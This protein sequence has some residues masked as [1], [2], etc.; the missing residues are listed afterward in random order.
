MK[1]IVMLLCC[2][3]TALIPVRVQALEVSAECACLFEPVSGTVLYEKNGSTKHAMASTTKIMTALVAME[4]SSPEE[5]VTVSAR[6]AGQEGSSAYLK[7]GETIS[8]ENLLYG[9]MLN[10]GNDAAVAVAEHVGGN[11]ENFVRMMNDKAAQLGLKNTA[12]K[13]PSGLDA[14]GH[15]TTAKELARLA[16]EA[17]KIPKFR[18]IVSTKVKAVND[19]AQTVYFS[20]HN[21]MLKLYEGAIGVKT[22]F[23]KAVGRCLVSAAERDGVMLIAVTLNAPDDWNDH[24]NM[25]DSGFNRV[26]NETAVKQGTALKTVKVDGKTYRFVAG[27]DV[28]LPQ[29]DGRKGDVEIILH[30]PEQIISPVN[31]GEKVGY[32]QICCNGSPVAEIGILSEEE[33]RAADIVRTRSGFFQHFSKIARRAFI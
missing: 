1:K 19:G 26:V 22:G 5:M 10:S 20:N 13:N 18:E 17:M 6:A 31:Q 2:L 3:W 25:L 30:M 27:S 28:V 12:Y 29:I 33:I 11:E 7:E 15:Y 23:T 8:M 4:N 14:E 32:A 9:L 21:K 24:K 16:Y